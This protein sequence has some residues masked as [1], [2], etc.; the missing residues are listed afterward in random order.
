MATLSGFIA[1][2]E[3]PLKWL[4]RLLFIWGGLAFF[5]ALFQARLSQARVDRLLFII[6][7]SALIFSVIGLMQ[8]WLK[9][10]MP[11]FLPKSE[12]GIPTSLF[13]QINNMATY[14]VTAIMISVYLSTR[15]AFRR[16][17]LRSWVLIIATLLAAFIVGVSGSRIGTLTLI[18]SLTVVLPVVVTKLNKN[19][20]SQAL[21]LAVVIGFFGGAN[22]PGGDRLVD[23]A[24]AMQSG[25]SGEA[26][27]GMYAISM[28][29]IAESPLV[30]H[31]IGS[32]GPAWQFAKPEFYTENPEAKL[33]TK[34]VSH[35]HN[36]IIQWLVEGGVIAF[37]GMVLVVIGVILAG[38]KTSTNRAILSAGMLLPMALH[39]QV[40]LPFY[41]SV[42]HW[43]VFI[44]IIYSLLNHKTNVKQIGITKA[45]IN[46]TRLT[47]VS[48]TSLLIVF[49]AHTLRA[50]WDFVFYYQG[51]QMDTPLP[52]A[53]KN[54]Y[55]GDQA[56]WIDLSA[57]L[58]SSIQS[59][60][61]DNVRYYTVWGE[62]LK[63][64]QPDVDLFIKL[65][66][67]YEFL[68][69]KTNYCSNAHQALLLYPEETR[70]QNAVEFCKY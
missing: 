27:L 57:I 23:K 22:M 44:I 24:R 51:E 40:E 18:I 50:N 21:L 48:V 28:G 45:A 34:Y 39:T 9:L 29:L 33:L 63:A 12:K 11:F 32:F 6:V 60:L 31:G 26:R 66:D 17:N 47:V 36:E 4:F 2:V 41:M 68:G 8:I 16:I 69:D 54:P 14:Q 10:D 55:L 1:G 15:P 70:F 20:V 61:P 25:Y 67:A 3:Q 37:I 52:Y 42:I 13:Q 62:E 58:Y 49:Y 30:G 38:V 65:V 7:I 53:Y 46:L 5:F 35:P 19:K 56:R 64:S 59:G 43:F